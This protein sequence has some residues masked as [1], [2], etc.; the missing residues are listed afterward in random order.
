MLVREGAVGGGRH[1]G[2]LG[3]WRGGAGRGGLVEEVVGSTNHACKRLRG[4]SAQTC[5]PGS[6][7]APGLCIHLLS[8]CLREREEEREGGRERGREEEREGGRE[9]ESVRERE[10]ERESCSGT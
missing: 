2:C 3:G 6:S 10:R 7:T 5:Q 8:G 9:R 1:G 4:F